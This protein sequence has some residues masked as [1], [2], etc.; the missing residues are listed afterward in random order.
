[1]PHP[2]QI[3]PY[4]PDDC[5]ACRAVFVDSVRDGAAKHYT[6]EQ[7]AVW[8]PLG[9]PTP[10]FCEKLDAQQVYVATHNGE[11][12]GFMSLTSAGYLDLAFVLPRWMG[13]S[14]AQT[15]YERLAQWAH[16]RGLRYLS[17]HASHFARPFFARNGWTVDHPETV[18]KDGQFF[19]RF[20]M[21]IDL[22]NPK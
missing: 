10:A 8:A 2:F 13:R 1:M 21:S 3:R 5:T 4:R 12:I 7:R 15:L 22:E 19:E 20:A 16:I 11:I 18:T 14:V 9:P 17:T 6:P